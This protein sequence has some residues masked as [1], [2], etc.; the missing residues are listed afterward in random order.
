MF[1]G[2]DGEIKGF[3]RKIVAGTVLVNVAE[4]PYFV[5]GTTRFFENFALEGVNKS[6]ALLNS[7]AGQRVKVKLFGL[8]KGV[9]PVSASKNR[10]R[11]ETRCVI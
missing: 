4:D 2:L 7:A 6:L 11:G 3:L 8:H 9:F 5:A 1:L 10:T